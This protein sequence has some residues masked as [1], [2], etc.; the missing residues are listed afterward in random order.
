MQKNEK[1]IAV[2]HSN[3]KNL[4]LSKMKY[5]IIKF[6]WES[7]TKSESK[8]KKSEKETNVRH[9]KK[10][11]RSGKAAKS[12][13]TYTYF[14]AAVL[15]VV[16]LI[17]PWI[18]HLKIWTLSSRAAEVYANQNGICMD[19]FLYYKEVFVIAAGVGMLL[20]LVGENI[21]PDNIRT[22]TPVRDKKNRWILICVLVYGCGATLSAVFSEDGYTAR[23]GGPTDGEG[24]FA[25]ISYL[26][27]FL[28]A[29][30]YF[31]G[32]KAL[33]LLRRTLTFLM[34]FT[35]LAACVEFIC[36]PLF[37][38]PL[39][40]GLLGGAEYQDYISGLQNES[41]RSFVTLTFYN[42]NYFGG[43]CLLLLPF[44]QMFLLRSRRIWQRAG[45]GMLLAGMAFCVIAAKSTTSLYLGMGEVV[46]L[47]ALAWIPHRDE[48]R[49]IGI[50]MGIAAGVSALLLAVNAAGDGKLTYVA[51]NALTN[52]SRTQETQILFELTD[53]R[54]EENYLILCAEER[55]LVVEAKNGVVRFYDEDGVEIESSVIDEG[56]LELTGK[57][58]EGIRV[59]AYTEGLG[60]EMGYDDPVSFYLKDDTFFGIGQNGAYLTEVSLGDMAE[61]WGTGA[62]SWF[63]GRGYV[64]VNTLAMLKDTLLIGRGAGNF[65]LYFPQNDYV[66]L[67]NTHGSASFYM[68]KPHSM[69]LQTAV[70]HGGIALLAMLALFAGSI[71]QYLTVR[72]QSAAVCEVSC[73]TDAS[74]AAFVA[75]VLYSCLND[76]IITVNPVFWILYGVLEASL[77]LLAR[78]CM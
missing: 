6:M 9:M 8:E 38:I 53:I 60:F 67:L 39:F 71:V 61:R 4:L 30:N 20:C 65:A 66:G 29:M 77:F 11:R 31:C 54:I 18:S 1:A 46:A 33:V 47:T 13:T 37:E 22:D 58:Y 12:E 56:T 34:V 14:F 55:E 16:L 2:L 78:R 45:Y 17:V 69:Y 62:Y 28:G 41:Y 48:R 24:V 36:G 21:F 68:D 57:G 10:A 49:D 5:C 70:N 50:N 59:F 73:M 23:M 27:L 75:F 40:Q 44:A 7:R 42:P 19:L 15:C 64:W 26:I 52:R 32:E 76:S 25:V 72:K 51:E 43:F 3:W 63:T 35:V 74:F